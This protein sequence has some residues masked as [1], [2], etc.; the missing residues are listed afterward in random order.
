MHSKYVHIFRRRVIMFIQE[1][2]AEAEAVIQTAKSMCQA[3]RTAP[4]AKGMDF[5]HT[6][7]LTDEEKKKLADEM[8]RLADVFGYQFFHRDADNL[9]KAQAVVLIGQENAVHGLNE[10]CQFCGFKNCKTCLEAGGN[11]AY[12]AMDLGI[13]IG[14]AVSVATDARVDNRVMFSN[15][16]AAMEM[17]LL[18]DR[19]CQMVGIPLSVSGKSPFFDR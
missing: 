2:Q 16:R 1:K 12:T 5:V 15:G 19:V 11:C 10:G 3:A 14:S 4:K 17:K 9:R 6:A 7:I 18:G 13:A 8:D